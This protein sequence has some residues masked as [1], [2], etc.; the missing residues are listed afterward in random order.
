MIHTHI[1]TT[2]ILTETVRALLEGLSG[3]GVRAVTNI[4]A[5]LSSSRA[6]LELA[7]RYPWMYAAIGVHPSDT[8]ELS[9][10]GI[11]WLREAAAGEKVVAIGEI[12]LDYYW[13]EP[14]H[15]VQKKWFS[16][17]SCPGRA[18]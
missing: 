10:D 14:E 5:S 1:M 2:R 12:G 9:E 8:G 13:E 4:G 16:R 3:A 7:A 11:G 15:E 6:T 18:N 17:G